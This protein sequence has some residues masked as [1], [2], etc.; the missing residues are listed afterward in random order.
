[1]AKEIERKFL[2]KACPW[3]NFTP[4]LDILQGYLSYDSHAT[5]RVRWQQDSELKLQKGFITIKGPKVNLTCDEFE[6]EIPSTDAAE[7]I[8]SLAKFSISKRRYL[9]RYEDFLWEVDE[10]GLQNKGLYLAELELPDAQTKF[11]LPDW[12]GTEVTKD[13]RYSNLNLAINPW[14]LWE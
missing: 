3:T 9:I 12:I 4:Y 11:T 13:L 6:Y 8:T 1:M 10:F 14:Q 7:L 5:V 2:I